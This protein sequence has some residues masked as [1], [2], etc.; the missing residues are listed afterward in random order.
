MIDKNPS[1]S[2]DW[3]G[4]PIGPDVAV[5]PLVHDRE[6]RGRTSVLGPDGEPMSVDIPRRR[7]GFVLGRKG[8]T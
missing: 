3:D 4:D 8:D 1:D 5:C 6:P 7:I 2:F